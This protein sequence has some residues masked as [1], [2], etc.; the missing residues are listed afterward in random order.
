[1]I[2]GFIVM[3][4]LNRCIMYFNH[5]LCT[6]SVLFPS[7]SNSPPSLPNSSPVHCHVYMDGK[8]A[9][10]PTENTCPKGYL[11]SWGCVG[12][13]AARGSRHTLATP[14]CSQVTRQGQLLWRG[15]KQA[16]LTIQP[17]CS[18]IKD[19]LREGL[20]PWPFTYHSYCKR[21]GSFYLNKTNSEF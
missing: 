6:N 3:T 16:L 2:V 4:F 9:S 5:I 1:M 20:V 13:R 10:G 15:E 8:F 7:P 21:E 19:Q 12:T 17:R 18:S 11:S 14:S